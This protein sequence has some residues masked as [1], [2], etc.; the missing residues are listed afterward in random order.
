MDKN[1]IVGLVVILLIA[2]GYYVIATPKKTENP[3]AQTEVL[4]KKPFVA[5]KTFE[6]KGLNYAY[7]VKEIRVKLNDM[8]KINFTNTEGFHDFRIDELGVASQKIG[9]GKTESLEFVASKAGTFEYYCSVGQHR[10]NGMWGK[11]IVE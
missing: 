3:V 4:A 6:V 5:D 2:G 8:V 10:A 9:E 7:D 1:I 11:I